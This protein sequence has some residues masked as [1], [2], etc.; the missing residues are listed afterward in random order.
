M[1]EPQHQLRVKVVPADPVPVPNPRPPKWR[2]DVQAGPIPVML[3]TQDGESFK[4]NGTIGG[5]LV[6][7]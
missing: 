7:Q 1:D 6:V 4:L 5:Y 3:V 2:Q